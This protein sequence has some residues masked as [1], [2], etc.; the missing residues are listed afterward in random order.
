VRIDQDPGEAEGVVAGVSRFLGS[1]PLSWTARYA[2]APAGTLSAA[3]VQYAL[4]PEPSIAPF[5]LFYFNIALVSWLGGRGPGLLSLALSAMTAN[6]LF[7]PPYGAFSLAGAALSATIL[8]LVGAG[9]VSLLCTAF[10]SALATARR[11]SEMLERQADLL[12]R[13]HDEIA[14]DVAQRRLVEAALRA[15][16]EKLLLAKDAA[17]MGLWD[18][19]VSTGELV[20][21]QRCK[22]LYAVPPDALMTYERFLLAVHPEDRGRVDRQVKEA[23]ERRTSFDAEMRVPWP[24]GTVR[25]VASLGRAYHDSTGA[26]VRM[27]GMVLD[28]TE[29]KRAEEELRDADRRKNEFLAM[30]SHELRNPLAPIR[31]SVYIL[32]RADPGGEQARRARAVIDRQARHLTRLVDDLLDVTRISRGKIRLQRQRIE[33]GE[34]L[35]RAAEDH[36]ETFSRLGIA[37]EVAVG[38]LPVH[39]QGDPTRLDQVVGNLLQNAAKFTPRGGRTT[40]S[41][42]RAS[43]GNAAIVVHDTGQGIAFEMLPRIFEPFSQ[44]EKTLDRSVGGLGLGLALVRGLVELHGGSV[45]ARSDGDGRGAEFVVRLPLDRAEPPRLTVVPS[46]RATAPG[47][48]VL[49]IEDNVDAAETLKEALEL[50]DH[51]VEVAYAG[52]EGLEKARTFRPDVVLCDIG[53]PG[54]DGYQIARTL[55]ADPE[56][57]AISLVALTGYALPEDLEKARAAGF[58]RHLAKPPDLDELERTIAQVRTLAS[59]G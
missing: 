10:R 44:G 41:L 54:M 51:V 49:V 19:N 55:R 17:K 50:A 46:A 20:W 26:P 13:A 30:L 43:D 8:F 34:L 12:R 38:D 35:R 11:T 2:L 42:E 47:R 27:T 5:S 59:A 40:L 16:E 22:A 32:E 33:L 7:V 29:R 31:N 37:L 58:D 14:R 9:A 18:W 23:L 21:S 52:L 4:L 48:R 24:D 1:G 56:L 28:V 25:W 53:L 45:S 36:R 39:V 15:S 6:Y 57:R 3:A